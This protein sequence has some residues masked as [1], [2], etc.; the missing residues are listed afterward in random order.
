MMT[1]KLTSLFFFLF[2]ASCNLTQGQESQEITEPKAVTTDD[3]D[4]LT[5]IPDVTPAPKIPTDADRN[6]YEIIKSRGYGYETHRVITDDGVL[7]TLVRIINPLVKTKGRPVVF[8]HGLI[9]SGADFL[10]GS[11]D[12]Y[13]NEITDDKSVGGNLGFEAAKRGFDVWLPNSRGN[14]YS[15]LPDGE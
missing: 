10:I 15:P 13:I 6:I 12:G 9:A 8:H 11:D 7:L 3:K 14:V 2:F 1:M 4:G 5:D